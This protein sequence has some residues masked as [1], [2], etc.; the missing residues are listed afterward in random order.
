[1]TGK[2]PAFLTKQLN[3]IENKMNIGREEARIDNVLAFLS[4]SALCNLV[5]HNVVFRLV[6]Q[7]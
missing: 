6:S 5:Q 7:W 1:M 2:S 4:I 3:R